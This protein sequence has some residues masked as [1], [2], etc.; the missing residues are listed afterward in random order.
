[1]RDT[2]IIDDL[3]QR[4]TTAVPSAVSDLR[5]DLESNFR[6]V[7]QATF[8]RLDLVTRE[9]LEVQKAVLART[10]AKV[11]A[12]EQR[13]AELEAAEQEAGTGQRQAGNRAS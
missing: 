12:L 7:L 11:E 1:M 4:L 13:V 9:E 3:V 8:A 10:R 6:A 5:S 2:R